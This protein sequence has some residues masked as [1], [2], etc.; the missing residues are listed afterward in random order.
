MNPRHTNRPLPALRGVAV[1]GAREWPA[2]Q[3]NPM[4]ASRASARLGG[5]R[6][7]I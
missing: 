4:T 5:I 6:I 7:R 1:A 3:G 2:P